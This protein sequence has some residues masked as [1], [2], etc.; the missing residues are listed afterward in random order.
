M[1]MWWADY[2][3]L[4]FMWEWDCKEKFMSAGFVI[5]LR[6]IWM[7]ECRKVEESVAEQLLLQTLEET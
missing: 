3:F 6:V 1:Q 4:T 5:H 7:L 2:A